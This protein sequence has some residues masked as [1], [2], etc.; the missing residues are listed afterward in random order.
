[1]FTHMSCNI[2]KVKWAK[3]LAPIFITGRVFNLASLV[4]RYCELQ[5]V[6][7]A[8]IHMVRDCHGFVEQ[9]IFTLSW[10]TH[11][12]ITQLCVVLVL[13]NL[14]YIRLRSP[15]FINMRLCL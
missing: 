14:H 11:R 2:I 1:M 13:H 6:T 12:H 5:P 10:Y 4:T 7:H 15:T 8:A 9:C 3:I